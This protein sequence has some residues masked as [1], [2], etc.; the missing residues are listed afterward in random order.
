MIRKKIC[1]LGAY[2]VGKT[3]LVRRFV[4][5]EFDERYQTTVGV[6]ID[7]KLCQVGEQQVSLVIWDLHGEDR[8]QEVRSS[9][10]RGA[11]GAL[12][13]AD[14]TRLESLQVMIEL[15]AR[16]LE[17][18]PNAKLVNLVNKIDREEDFAISPDEWRARIDWGPVVFSSASSGLG[19][20]Q[21]FIE[22]AG[23]R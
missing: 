19:V 10:M 21:A 16:L 5:S 6:K 13:V 1:L 4:H 14:G 23:G 12:L 3:S 18:N 22:L 20:E 11:A 7:K 9:Y 8:W 15:R 2:A 17:Q